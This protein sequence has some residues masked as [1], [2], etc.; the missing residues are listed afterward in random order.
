VKRTAIMALWLASLAGAFLLGQ[1][2]G[3][4]DP[5]PSALDAPPK[6]ART[7]D[8][9]PVPL[10]VS[11]PVPDPATVDPLGAARSL[12]GEGRPREAMRLVEDYLAA[13]PGEAQALFL[14]SDLRQMTGDVEGALD[15]LFE[16]LRFPP[17]PE[18]AARARQRLD[19][20][21]NARE[22]QLI[23]TGDLAGLVAY[24][25]A[26]VLADPSWDGYRLRLARWLARSGN[27][28][29][30]AGLIREVGVVGTTQEQ[31]DQ[32]AGEIELARTSL[33]VEQDGPAMFTRGRAAGAAASA[34]V[35]FLVDTGATMSGLAESRL[36]V[37]GAVRVRESVSVHTANGVAQLP[38]YRLQAL[39]LGP[40]RLED[41]EVLGFDHLPRDAD[42]LLGMDVLGRLS[43]GLPGTVGTPEDP[44]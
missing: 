37:L 16:I 8:P 32:L 14:L 23:N 20:L 41:L 35:R 39:T 11:D 15:P 29:A 3:S 40:V 31:I 36:R 27:L 22:Q 13:S 34:N 38:V 18:V 5:I 24:F 4:L 44:R 30:A 2:Q 9:V 17:T 21:I 7:A 19:L 1:R 26:L 12:I 28:D 25:E 43:G 6:T 42:G 33:P 10:A